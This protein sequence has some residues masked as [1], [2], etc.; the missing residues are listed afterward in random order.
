MRGPS[1]IERIVNVRTGSAKRSLFAAFRKRA[2]AA[3]TL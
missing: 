2:A 3:I 1:V